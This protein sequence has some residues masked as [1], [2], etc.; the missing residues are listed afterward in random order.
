[1]DREAS[2]MFADPYE[3]VNS[4]MFAEYMHRLTVKLRR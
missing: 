3:N 1:M 2:N 4:C